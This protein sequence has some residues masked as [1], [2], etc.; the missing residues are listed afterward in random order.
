[1]QEFADFVAG[2]SHYFEPVVGY[3]SEFAGVVFHPCVDVGVVFEGAVE[4]KEIHVV[5]CFPGVLDASAGILCR[6]FSPR[7]RKGFVTQGVAWAGIWPRRW[8]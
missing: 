5:Y 3:G 8:R 4:A 7:F 6:A 2:V 1:M